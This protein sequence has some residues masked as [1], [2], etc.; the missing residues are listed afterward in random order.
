MT[1]SVCFTGFG[2][3]SLSMIEPVW[4]VKYVQPLT[5]R[6][7]PATRKP[8]VFLNIKDQDHAQLSL[9]FKCM[10]VLINLLMLILMVI[11]LVVAYGFLVISTY[12]FEKR[13]YRLKQVIEQGNFCES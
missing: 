2:V 9:G 1:T 6:A 7:L 13:E 10:A 12:P 3:D 4:S 8:S 5:N 11:G